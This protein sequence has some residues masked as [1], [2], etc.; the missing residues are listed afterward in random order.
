VDTKT[1]NTGQGIP[2]QATSRA[3]AQ[4]P[5]PTRREFTL[6]E[7]IDAYMANYAG[8]DRGNVGRLAYWRDALG[9]RLATEV[10]PDDVAD[11]LAEYSL[12]RGR[13]YLGRDKQTGQARFK[14]RRHAARAPATVNR[15]LASL[16]GV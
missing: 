12:G 7:M 14:D 16:G 6:A 15:A 9:E 11:A 8:P 10:S 4:N 3:E 13:T 2:A 1:G 5:T